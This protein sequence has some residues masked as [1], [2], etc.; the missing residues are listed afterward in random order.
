MGSLYNAIII[1]PHA[2]ATHVFVTLYTKKYKSRAVLAEYRSCSGREP[3]GDILETSSADVFYSSLV[4]NLPNSASESPVT[5][6]PDIRFDT[7]EITSDP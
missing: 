4:E 5:E 2:G 1:E 7:K 3:I 6:V